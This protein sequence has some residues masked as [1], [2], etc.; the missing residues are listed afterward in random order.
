[1]IMVYDGAMLLQMPRVF[2]I[3]DFLPCGP[4]FHTIT[5][6]VD[7]GGETIL[8]TPPVVAYHE[9]PLHA[10]QDGDGADL[11][12]GELRGLECAAHALLDACHVAR[13]RLLRREAAE[14]AALQ[15]ATEDATLLPMETAN[16]AD[17]PAP[18]LTK[19]ARAQGSDFQLCGVV[20]LN[21]KEIR[22]R[23]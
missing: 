22:N 5:P 13:G 4:C 3:F 6:S 17:E 18:R 8:H 14:I 7:I 1:M 16:A 21:E 15:V 2:G 12:R 19:Q 10:P 23:Y 20:E 11:T 9:R